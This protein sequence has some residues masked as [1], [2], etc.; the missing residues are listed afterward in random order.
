MPLSGLIEDMMVL[1]VC[2]LDC[3]NGFRLGCAHRGDKDDR[4]GQ[5]FEEAV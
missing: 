5:G 2:A 1:G 3:A 4:R